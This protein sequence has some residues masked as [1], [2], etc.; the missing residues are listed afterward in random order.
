MVCDDY[1]Y[2]KIGVLIR[3]AAINALRVGSKLTTDYIVES[4]NFLE[5]DYDMR[6]LKKSEMVRIET[7]IHEAGH[8]VVGQILD[9]GSITYVSMVSEGRANSGGHGATYSAPVEGGINA[10]CVCL[11]SLAAVDLKLHEQGSG[12][13]GDLA[14]ATKYARRLVNENGNKGVKLVDIT[15]LDKSNE[16]LMA[17]EKAI[18][19]LLYEQ[20]NRAKLIIQSNMDLLDFIYKELLVKGYVFKSEILEFC[21][22]NQIKS[23][24]S[25]YNTDSKNT[26][27]VNR[28]IW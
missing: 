26:I 16:L 22:K 20:Y 1:S 7:A 12:Y 14:R 8:A 10:L 25:S 23:N 24:E 19:A 11:G 3:Y 2:K 18:H 13:E 4:F 17:Q 9:S 5:Y 6:E 15:G 28:V 27:T 21:E